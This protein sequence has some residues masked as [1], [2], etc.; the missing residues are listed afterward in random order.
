MD[1]RISKMEFDSRHLHLSAI[2]SAEVFDL[3]QHEFEQR[4]GKHYTSSTNCFSSRI[5]CGDCGGIYGS[6]VWHS[7]SKYLRT[8]WQCNGKFK[9]QEKCTTPHF[10]EDDLKALFADSF[11]SLNTDF[12]SVFAAYDD[13]I[14]DL[15]YNTSLEKEAQSIQ[16]ECD[17]VLELMRQAV[18]ENAQTALDQADYQRRYG[19]LV[20]RYENTKQSLTEIDAQITGRRVKCKNIEAFMQ[21]LRAQEH[22]LTEFDEGLWNAT[23]DCIVVRSTTKF[24]DG[25]ELPWKTV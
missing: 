17:A 6:K 5:I 14:A 12:E 16:S 10:Y 2:V 15:T 22:L 25:T 7:A 19:A 18:A 1:G 21:T 20:A 23:V 11:N 9:N 13:I 4:K 3:V 24:K 8:I